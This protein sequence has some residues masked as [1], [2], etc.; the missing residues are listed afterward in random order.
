MRSVR[1]FGVG[2]FALALAACGS[3]QGQSGAASTAQ[4]PSAVSNN[5]CGAFTRGAP[6]VL[7]A[8]CDGTAT[9]TVTVAGEQHVLRGGSCLTS[10]TLF[11]LNAGALLSP[12]DTRPPPNYV[13]LVSPVQNGPFSDA[14]LSVR[15]DGRSYVLAQNTGQVSQAGGDFAGTATLQGGEPVQITGSFT[16]Q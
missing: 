13:G 6:G 7:N 8:F 1:L 14:V 4:P 11:T 9:V 15:L 5:T 16:C 2:V 12:S 3:E 10:M